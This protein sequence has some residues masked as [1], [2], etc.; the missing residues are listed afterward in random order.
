[1]A[2]L[3]AHGTAA[4]D[5]PVASAVGKIVRVLPVSVAGPLEALREVAARRTDPDPP[6]PETTAAL[7]GASVDRRRCRIDYAPTPAK[8]H[9]I[10]V[11]PWAVVVRFG[12]W[13]VLGWSHVAADRRMYR[14]DR[15]LSVEVLDETSPRPRTSTP[16][17]PSRSRCPRAGR[18]SWTSWSTRH[19]RRSAS[20]CRAAS[21][22]RPTGRPD[23]A[24]R[25]DPQPGVVRVRA[26][27]VPRRLHRRGRRR[28]R[29]AV[30][31][32]GDRLLRSVR[33]RPA[34]AR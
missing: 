16:S 4:G 20:G 32:L 7:V 2:V 26:R 33:G 13:Y 34:P 18:T 29:Q 23:P 5:D 3:E 24:H 31:A 10:E 30:R 8:R 22:G 1:M 19:P 25:L 14:I 28:L 6:R 21:A 9:L 11:D 12:R 15:V 17:P 27:R